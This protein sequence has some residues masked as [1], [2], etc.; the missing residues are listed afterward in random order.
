MLAVCR[1]FLKRSEKTALIIDTQT[2]ISS[3]APIPRQCLECAPITVCEEAHRKG[4]DWC[5]SGSESVV[6]VNH[7]EDWVVPKFTLERKPRLS[8]Y[9]EY[10][11]YASRIR[12]KT[13]SGLTHTGFSPLSHSTCQFLFSMGSPLYNNANTPTNDFLD[14]PTGAMARQPSQQS[15][16]P[17]SNHM[18]ASIPSELINPC[19]DTLQ[20]P[21]SSTIDDLAVHSTPTSTDSA[22]ASLPPEPIDPYPGTPQASSSCAREYPAAHSMA[23]STDSTMACVP[24]ELVD[25]SLKALQAFSSNT[26]DDLASHPVPTP[27]SSMSRHTNANIIPWMSPKPSAPSPEAHHEFAP[28][29][30]PPSNSVH[31]PTF[32]MTENTTPYPRG[33]LRSNP[34]TP[35]RLS[36]QRSGPSSFSQAHQGYTQP[37]PNN[38]VPY[39]HRVAIFDNEL[40]RVII[41]HNG[42]WR[43]KWRRVFRFMRPRDGF[44]PFYHFQDCLCMDGTL[45]NFQASTLEFHD[46]VDL[47]KRLYP[48]HTLADRIIYDWFGRPAP[49]QMAP[50]LDQLARALQS[51]ESE[52]REEET[53]EARM[54]AASHMQAQMD[55]EPYVEP[56]EAYVKPRANAHVKQHF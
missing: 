10:S 1:A 54:H 55:A 32:S 5:R 56:T 52:L 39:Y 41:P 36:S 8:W 51:A 7:G 29:M 28:T 31:Q 22:V 25:L 46:L 19:L 49:T 26:R 9:R 47:A 12:C 23:T 14:L 38:P 53:L 33:R 6:D 35:A 4:I 15:E 2:S 44:L 48:G 16:H 18:V 13:S 37:P 34:H 17:Y 24:S 11:P 3:T 30:D 40:G 27:T 20:G 42:K 43:M 45:Y 50:A 21:F